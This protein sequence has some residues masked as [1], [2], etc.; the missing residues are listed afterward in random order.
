VARTADRM[1]QLRRTAAVAEAFGL[2]C[3]IIS[4]AQARGRYPIME[5]GDLQGAI[6][7]PDDGKA[8]P[9]DLTS[10]LARG[11]RAGGA[12]IRERTRVTG[13][14]TAG[15]AVTGVVTGEGDVEAEIV[16]NCAV[17]GPSRWAAGA[18]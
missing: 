6:W 16:V 12:T 15:G 4:P 11:A 3:E 14:L 18:A 5:A 8:N 13:I 2:D 10:A 1:V 9:T 17:S 7:L